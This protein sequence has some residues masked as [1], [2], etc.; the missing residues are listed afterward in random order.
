M[1]LNICWQQ[2]QR[3][4]ATAAVTPLRAFLFVDHGQGG[5]GNVFFFVIVNLDQ[6]HCRA[7]TTLPLADYRRKG[8]AGP[9]R[10]IKIDIAVGCNDSFFL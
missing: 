10:L 3:P 6:Q 7:F 5:V 9:A 8:F 2:K 4:T 1:H